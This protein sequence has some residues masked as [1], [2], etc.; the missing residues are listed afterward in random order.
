MA[1]AQQLG[2]LSNLASGNGQTALI[3][4]A[5]LCPIGAYV[6][7]VRWAHRRWPL[8]RRDAVI[9]EAM[10]EGV[11]EGISEGIKPPEQHPC[12]FEAA[13]RGPAR[14]AEDGGG[15]GGGHG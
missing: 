1:L 3:I 8:R 15:H 9:G 12:A 5:T 11:S 6:M 4:A 13:T 7:W 2:C 14:R 10:E